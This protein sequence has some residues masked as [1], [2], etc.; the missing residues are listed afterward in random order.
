MKSAAQMFLEINPKTFTT[1]RRQ[2]PEVKRN[3]RKS[4]IEKNITI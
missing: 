2:A 4:Y 3:K 1:I